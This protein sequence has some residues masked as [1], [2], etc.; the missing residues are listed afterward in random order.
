MQAVR[1]A[2]VSILNDLGPKPYLPMAGFAHYRDA[3]QALVFGNDNPSRA[4]GRIASVQ[5]LGRSG[6]L[7]VGADFVKRYFQNS[8]V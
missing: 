7:K 2:E 3:V 1:D 4:D 8:Q 5:T 6:A